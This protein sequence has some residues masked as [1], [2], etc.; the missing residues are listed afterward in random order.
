MEGGMSVETWL[1]RRDD[2]GHERELQERVWDELAGLEGVETSAIRVRVSGRTVSLTG[3][4]PAWPA[5]IEAERAAKR[6]PGV[7]MVTNELQVSPPPENR[8]TDQELGHAVR[9]ALRWD[10]A[11][12][13]ERIWTNVANGCVTLHGVVSYEHERVAAERAVSYLRGV[14]AVANRIT[15]A[16]ASRPRDLEKRIRE[17]LARDM[18]N[19]VAVG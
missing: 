2:S 11:V 14:V 19:H 17:T 1:A 10:V 8:W 16:V 6:V 15:V 7:L 4:V 18:Q 9:Q 5:A 13:S 3:T 12:P